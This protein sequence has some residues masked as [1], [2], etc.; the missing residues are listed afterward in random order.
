[1]RNMQTRGQQ[2]GFTLIELVV[3]IV[4]LA[5][6]AAT[7]IPRFTGMSTDARKAAVQGMYGAVQSA[8]AIAHAQ[9]LVQGKTTASA[10][11]TM[12]GQTVDLVYGYPAATAAGIGAALISY[13]GFD[14]ASGAFTP[15]ASPAY[16]AAN[17]GVAYTAATATAAAQATL[18][19]ANCS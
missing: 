10:T 19:V 16:T 8:M 14:F 4:I 9:A 7:A 18:G 11:I 13:Q 17:C 3:V 2:S 12:E 15:T 6:L 1:M 5:I